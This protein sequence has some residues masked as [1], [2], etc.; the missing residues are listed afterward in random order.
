[1]ADWLVF[2][3]VASSLR[4]VDS[5][6]VVTFKALHATFYPHLLRNKRSVASIFVVVVAVVD[7]VDDGNVAVVAVLLFSINGV[8]Q[9]Q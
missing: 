4:S 6:Y 7:A 3:I 2:V 5:V 9:F 1:M 8:E